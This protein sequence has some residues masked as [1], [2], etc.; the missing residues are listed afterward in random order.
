MGATRVRCPGCSIILVVPESFSGNKVRC[1]VC[2]TGFQ[3]PS[4]SDAEILDWIG[5]RSK[6]DTAY[7]ESALAA[8]VSES[9]GAGAVSAPATST[10][11]AEPPDD[12]DSMDDD[13]GWPAGR[14]EFYLQRMGKKGPVFEFST[15]LFEDTTFRSSLPRRCMRCGTKHHIQPHLVI[16]SHQRQDCAAI[17]SDYLTERITFSE[18][19]ARFKPMAE[20]LELL[21]EVPRIPAPAN[22]PFP[23]W[24]CDMCNPGGLVFAMN[25]IDTRTGQGHCHLQIERLWRAEEFL[26]AAG[27]EGSPAHEELLRALEGHPETPWDTL[28]GAVQQ[29]LRQWY[30]PKSGERFLAYVP[31]RTHS[32]T[33]DGMAGLVVTNRR[34][35]YNTSMRHREAEKGQALE[36]DFAMVNG[37]LKLHVQA[38]SWEVKNLVVDKPGLERLRRALAKEKYRAVWH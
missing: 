30:K 1:S 14:D 28:A 5:T 36:L 4:I 26:I 21:P 6:D 24:V 29:R 11:L 27:G 13:H 23:Y 19:E 33:E 20:V 2:R 8:G 10:A 3:I 16:F 12:M 18:K 37:Q 9:D 25:E 35:I 38:A 22:Q 17:E 34:L 7:G 31:D 15:V 32:R